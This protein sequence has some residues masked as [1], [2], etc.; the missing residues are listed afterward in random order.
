MH[1]GGGDQCPIYRQRRGGIEAAV[2]LEA[3]IGVASIRAGLE[4]T[5]PDREVAS[6]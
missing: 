2:G 4:A 3:T 6:I 5:L 1:G